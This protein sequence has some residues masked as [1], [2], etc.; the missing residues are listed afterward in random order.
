[1]QFDMNVKPF[2]QFVKTVSDARRKG[3]ANEEHKLLG[4]M[5]KLISNSFY[6]KCITNILKYDQLKQFPK[7]NMQKIFEETRTNHIQI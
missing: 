1:M 7:A 6:D 4:E 3:D 5:M 2:Q